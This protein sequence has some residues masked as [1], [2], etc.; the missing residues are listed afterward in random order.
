ME[1]T[2]GLKL[3]VTTNTKALLAE[4]SI[5]LEHFEK[6]PR[7]KKTEERNLQYKTL[8]E[9]KSIFD[10]APD[11]AILHAEEVSDYDEGFYVKLEVQWDRPE[12]DDEWARRV[13]REVTTARDN[14]RRKEAHEK[15]EYERLRLKYGDD[16]EVHL[17][18][19]NDDA[20]R[21]VKVADIWPLY[22]EA[23]QRH[24]IKIIAEDDE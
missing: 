22:K 5:S 14:I 10:E 24:G 19:L 4:H 17:E 8:A 12:T 15:A 3:Q 16:I 13:I 18:Q 21:L 11:D 20:K 1:D 6:S 9:L 23:A 7:G 2:D